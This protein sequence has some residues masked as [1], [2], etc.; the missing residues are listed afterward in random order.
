[1][2]DA[3]GFYVDEG[4]R[5]EIMISDKAWLWFALWKLLDRLQEGI[6][7]FSIPK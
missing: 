6:S 1:M 4:K 7:L 5:N 3:H 2:L